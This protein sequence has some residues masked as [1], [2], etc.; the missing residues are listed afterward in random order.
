MG[1]LIRSLVLP[2]LLGFTVLALVGVLGSALFLYRE[3][4]AVHPLLGWGVVAVTAAG[5]VLLIVIPVARLLVLPRGIERPAVSTG[6]SWDRFVRR[7]AKR[8]VRNRR[9]RDGYPGHAALGA[10]LESGGPGLQDATEGT[11]SWLDG[12]CR[13]V[14]TRHAAAVFAATAVSQS[15]RLDTMIVFSAQLRM[16]REIAELYYQRPGLRE[17]VRLYANVGATAFLAGEIEDSEVLAVL[18][19]PVTAG[20]SGLIPVGGTDP[21]VSLLVNSLLDGSTNAFLTL[22]VGIL[23]RRHCGLQVQRDRRAVARSASVEAAGL[24]GDVVGQGARKVAAATRRAVTRSAVSGP[25]RAAESAVRGTGRLADA[26]VRGT[27]RAAEGVA[28]FGV[29]IIDRLTGLAGRMAGRKGD[30][31]P[32]AELAGDRELRETLEFWET[33]SRRFRGRRE[34]E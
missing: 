3:A 23:A 18:G 12:E 16:I 33:V 15:G 29:S 20:V 5:V 14:I 7:Y 11:V 13:T 34:V 8:L 2:A 24:L 4:S 31:P 1:R 19:A 30:E 32:P 25:R 6:R 10:A 17:I 21:I 22:R 9:V 28:D 26:A 27:G